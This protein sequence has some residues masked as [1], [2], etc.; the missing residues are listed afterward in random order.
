MKDDR[1]SI[2]K[3]LNIAMHE[4]QIFRLMNS[5]EAVLIQQE[6]KLLKEELI[7]FQIGM[8]SIKN[9]QK[10]SKAYVCKNNGEWRMILSKHF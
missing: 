6:V 5:L 10:T 2:K 3:A 8:V 1:L 4:I 9:K 7:A